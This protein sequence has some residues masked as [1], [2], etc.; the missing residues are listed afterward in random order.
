M[1]MSPSAR[2]NLAVGLFDR[3][4][5]IDSALRDVGSSGFAKS[6]YTILVALH[7]REFAQ[8]GSVY[9]VPL[10]EVP[11]HRIDSTSVE[12]GASWICDTPP[13]PETSA[14]DVTA[15]A[16]GARRNPPADG[17]ALRALER[18]SH[19][20]HGHLGRGGAVLIVRVDTLSEQQAICS[21]LLH[22]ASDGVLTH[23]VRPATNRVLPALLA[24]TH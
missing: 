21:M 15:P 2:I 14:D 11:V 1:P 13:R 24:H 10:L 23:Q 4:V 22:Y 3:L 16:G 9:R 8:L 19:R 20:L 12:Q 18:H 6:A 17:A 5:A 7:S